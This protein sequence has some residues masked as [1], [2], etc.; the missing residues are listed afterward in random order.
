MSKKEVC[1]IADIGP[2][3][4]HTYLVSFYVKTIQLNINLITNI[5][6]TNQNSISNEVC[7]GSFP[8]FTAVSEIHSLSC[9]CT[10]EIFQKGSNSA[11]FFVLGGFQYGE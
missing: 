10:G 8:R 11:E 3:G 4:Y 7:F 1:F 5:F 6:K 2:L 9:T